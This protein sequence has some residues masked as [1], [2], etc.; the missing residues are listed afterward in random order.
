[1]CGP[2]RHAGAQTRSTKTNRSSSHQ[3]KHPQGTLYFCSCLRGEPACG[4]DGSPRWLGSERN[5]RRP[6]LGCTAT[7]PSSL[8]QRLTIRT[9]SDLINSPAA[10]HKRLTIIT[11]A[12]NRDGQARVYIGGKSLVGC[13]IEPK[14]CRLGACFVEL[15]WRKHFALL[16]LRSPALFE[17]NRAGRRW[18]DDNCWRCTGLLRRYWSC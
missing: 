3:K 7:R 9:A 5:T 18:N 17:T 13:W 12:K 10:S 11:H 14:E 15:G 4:G 16:L 8:L 6:G 1:M 2:N